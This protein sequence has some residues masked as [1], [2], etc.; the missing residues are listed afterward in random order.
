MVKTAELSQLAFRVFFMA[1]QFI[2]GRS[3]TGKTSFCINAIVKSLLEPAN[4]GS[5]ILLVPEQATY[6]AERAILS[7]KRIAGYGS[8]LAFF[9][10]PISQD[11]SEDRSCAKTTKRGPGL[12]IL[13]FDRLQFLVSGKNTARPILS[14]IGRQ[15]II[16]RILR[17]NNSRLRVFGPSANWPGLARLMAEVMAELHRYVKGP[18]DVEQLLE[19]LQEDERKSLSLLKFTDINLIFKEYLKFIEGRF[20]DPDIQLTQ[21][22]NAVAEV[23]FAKGARLW[24]D[25]FA[26][27]TASE[28]AMLTE[29]LKTVADAK[30]ALCLDP[31]N[32]D[33]KNPLFE[34]TDSAGLFYPTER[35]YAQ[36]VEIISRC[37]LE[38]LEPVKL[39]EQVRFSSSGQLA[40]LERNVFDSG[41]SKIAAAVNVRIVSA[42]NARAEVQ[43]VARQIIKLVRQNGCRYRDVA[44]IASDID[45]YQ[46]YIR[47]YFDDYQIPFFIDK[48]KSL[49]QHPV[50]CLICSA[51]QAVSGGFS[52][53]DIF[54]YLKTDL[55][56]VERCDVDLLENYCLAFGVSGS[57]WTSGN[58]W[59]FAG[60]DKAQFDEK[61][62]NQIRRQIIEPLM[63]LRSQ[64]RDDDGTQKTISSEEFARVVFDFLGE[65][66]VCETIEDWIERAVG[67]DNQVTANEHRQFY[68]RLVDIFDE[69]VEVFGDQRASCGDWLAILNSAFSQ[70][71]LA[72]IPPSLDQVLVGSIER[73]R[74]PDLKAVFL[75]GVTQRQF[76]APVSFE[77]VLTDEDR[78]AADSA[79]FALAETVAQTLAHRQY[80][81]YIAFTRA[82]EFLWVTYPL[83]DN[84]GDVTVRSQFIAGLESLFEGLGEEKV[85][86][87]QVDIE[88]V[89]SKSELADLLCGQLG[90]DIW[91]PWTGDNG[92][93]RALLDDI[94]GDKQLA[95]LGTDV[96]SAINYDNRPYLDPAVVEELLGARMI[97]SA[98]RLRTFAECPYKHFARYSLEL[99]ERKECKFEPL[100]V[101]DF[102]HR[103]LDSLLKRLNEEEKDFATVQDAQLLELLREQVSKIATEDAF[104]SSFTRH[105]LHN[106]FIISSAGEV[107]EN[108]V[109]A[110]AEM[111]R[112]GSFRPILSE[113]LF[114]RDSDT[115]GEYRIGPANDRLILLRGKIDR[116]DVTELDGEKVAI[117]FDYK[118][119]NMSF[120]W[121]RFYNG[122][123][124]QLPIYMLAVRNCTGQSNQRAGDEKFKIAGAFYMPV[125]V[126]P[127]VATLDELEKRADNFY[128]KAKGI[129]NGRFF[130]QLDT[131][132]KS[133]WSKFYN[134]SVT[135]G[136]GQYGNPDKSG[137]LEPDD[138]EKLLRFTEKRV[139][140]MA[141]EIF[142]GKIDVKPYRLGDESPCSYCKY[143]SVCRFDWQINDYSVLEP[144]GKLTA[145]ERMKA[146]DS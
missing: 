5:L 29:L 10:C 27:F 6:Q 63:R 31:S 138:F 54:T 106:A 139:I 132:I 37:K 36:L 9:G 81:A 11:S 92:R 82:S 94:C 30:I 74:H 19:K 69:L 140:A 43:F 44:V 83:I 84:K 129:F 134:F 115:L 47:A 8:G 18:E 125:E 91:L 17:D 72:L 45:G 13:S 68:D 75:I 7:D 46:H 146:I 133:G 21:A 145:L 111:V 143:K 33:L 57:D 77:G 93:L 62:V 135:K 4:N 12:N 99:K 142:S 122:L 41:A 79:D 53:S 85:T 114:G 50:I 67:K 117:V 25:G 131:T 42:P 109:L 136:K 61:R 144:V 16:H 66:G 34:D 128:Y 120:S 60:S 80:L 48:R 15:M 71:T 38:Q 32:V 89:Y 107:L 113:V 124:M 123:D 96:N 58:D 87:E 102:Y 35:T 108:C 110:I 55:V 104:L 26:G 95:Q 22:C 51:L 116:F 100:D 40:H 137:A 59:F 105:S 56:P 28:L 78:R 65:L 2:L 130:R 126:S 97:C 121:S 88:K 90:K 3:G 24:V 73:S 98:T 64:S 86:D 52:S 14:R 119:Q 112:A 101:G 49:N 141:A 20:V 76:P 39:T 23:G 118:R 70:L 127:K 1:V 103:V